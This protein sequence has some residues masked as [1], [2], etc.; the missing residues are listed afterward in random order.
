MLG[1][2]GFPLFN[3]YSRAGEEKSDSKQTPPWFA[4]LLFA[5]KLKQKTMLNNRRITPN[6]KWKMC[7]PV[8]L[9][10]RHFPRGTLTLTKIRS[11]C[12]LILRLC[13][14]KRFFFL[15]KQNMQLRVC[16]T[17]RVYS[18]FYCCLCGSETEWR[19]RD[20]S[21]HA[22]LTCSSGDVVHSNLV[23]GSNQNLFKRQIC[24]VVLCLC[25]WV[26]SYFSFCFVDLY[27]Y[28]FQQHVFVC[29]LFVCV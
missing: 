8:W 2:P 1:I 9:R 12:I 22:I 3:R 23:P 24:S 25:V 28:I 17:E 20:R 29:C 26:C 14:G 19:S 16:K 5:W 4:C 18:Y 10:G 21:R 7:F 11:V 13:F 6:T 15:A 27:L